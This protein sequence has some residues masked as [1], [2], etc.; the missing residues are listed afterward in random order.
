MDKYKSDKIKSLLSA[1]FI[2]KKEITID[3]A[4]K[5]ASDENI[6]TL[7]DEEFF[8]KIHE[9]LHEVKGK[10][11]IISRVRADVT[12]GMHRKIVEAS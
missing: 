1:S 3:D 5:R 2:K 7:C 12:G 11:A 8:E 4:I 10:S 6:L 9:L